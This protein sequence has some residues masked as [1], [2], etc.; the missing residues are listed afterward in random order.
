MIRTQSEFSSLLFVEA[1]MKKMNG[2]SGRTAKSLLGLVALMALPVAASSRGQEQISARGIVTPLASA[3]LVF[4]GEP[5]CLRVARENGD[6]DKGASTFLLEAP[7]GCVV[8]AHYHT[9]EEQLMVVQGDV[10]T[11]MDGMAEA[12]LGPGGFAMMPSKAMHW[13]TCKSKNTCLMFVTFDRPY[14]IVWAKQAK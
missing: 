14:D 3:N 4:D 1:D 13:F 5:A 11:G 2:I 12:T 10:L 8:P 6:P 9:A 7:S